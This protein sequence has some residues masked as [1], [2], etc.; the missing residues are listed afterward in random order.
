MP[1]RFSLILFS[2]RWLLFAAIIY[3]AA[4]FCAFLNFQ[5]MFS[6][7]SQPG[8]ITN[9]SQSLKMILTIRFISSIFNR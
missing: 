2:L 4:F 9:N 8:Q 1:R 3:F 6:F 7:I 5:R